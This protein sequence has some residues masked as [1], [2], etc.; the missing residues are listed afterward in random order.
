M[1]LFF[2]GGGQITQFGSKECYATN[3]SIVT[4]NTPVQANRM[5]GAIKKEYINIGGGFNGLAEVFKK[6]NVTDGNS[7]WR[8]HI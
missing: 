5:A 4:Q 6:G 7:V 8:L 3:Q 1:F 2:W